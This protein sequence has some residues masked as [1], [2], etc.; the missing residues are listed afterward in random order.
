MSEQAPKRRGRP[1]LPPEVK[2]ERA[3]ERAR[4]RK[5]KQSSKH[6]ALAKAKRVLK[7]KEREAAKSTAHL[8]DVSQPI[9]VD[10]KLEA[11][12]VATQ[13]A[14]G[15]PSTRTDGIECIKCKRKLPT[16]GYNK[17]KKASPD[18][19][20]VYDSVC[21][22]CRLPDQQADL[23]AAAFERKVQRRVTTMIR[24]KKDG[25]VKK[26]D[27]VVEAEATKRVKQMKEVRKEAHKKEVVKASE[28]RAEKTIS[29][30]A[31][32]E[33]ARRE[34]ARRRLLYFTQRFEGQEVDGEGELVAIERAKGVGYKADWVHKD[35]CA[36]LERFLADARAGKQPRL[37][38]FMPPRHGKSTLASRMFPAWAY[39][40]DPTL[41]II[42][43]SYGASLPE[44][45]SRN[46]RGILRDPEYKAIF[47]KTR[48]DPDRENVQGWATSKNGMYIPV[49]VGSGIT[50]KGADILII[51]DPFKGAE[52]AEN[53]NQREKVV[54]WYFSEAYTRLSPNAGVLII[55][56]RW[57]DAD[58][59]GSLLEAQK[60]QETESREILDSE[61][62]EIEAAQLSKFDNIKAISLASAAHKE[63]LV[64]V[65]K[66]EV[67]SFAAIADQNEFRLPDG[68]I[69]HGRQP[70]AQLLRRA[71]EALHPSRYP[72]E[73]LNK[74]RKNFYA[75]GRQRF[76]HALYQQKPVPDEG[77]HFSREMVRMVTP[78]SDQVRN[79]WLK[80][81]AWDLAAGQDA[82]HDWTVG[83]HGQMD[84]EGRIH[85]MEIVR[86]RFD[87]AHGVACEVLDEYTRNRPHMIGVEKGPLEKYLQPS[88]KKELAE[89]NKALNYKDRLTPVFAEGKGYALAPIQDPVMRAQPLQSVMQQ[90]MFV[91]S[92][93]LQWIEEAIQELIR[94]PGGVHDDIVTA[95]SWLVRLML[96]FEVP[97]AP[98]LKQRQRS[99]KHKLNAYTARGTR[100]HMAA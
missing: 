81:T 77:V 35:I 3:A 16:S 28:T 53:P 56:T 47:P 72:I 76:W 31:A 57:H 88:I 1:P 98:K 71:G 95:L 43:A 61:M 94:F 92:K 65:E 83:A 48:L 84:Y 55:L 5:S 74:I 85:V 37:M 18:S 62:A 87:G 11:T 49:G 58:L 4:A 64:D 45:F 42:A 59:A 7:R 40:Q 82:Q 30:N 24:G 8:A 41:E 99:W 20:V 66:W 93:D 68:R 29:E 67:V 26:S 23:A 38:L 51:D 22:A 73:R 100:G 79:G 39:G 17:L 86:G 34:L 13:P 2:A 27:P 91:F 78:H 96:K 12:G 14:P 21:K 32:R 19:P 25:R 44:Q 75:R 63:R 50:G 90:G 60:E 10:A 33:L 97:N 6:S 46:V 9:R 36:R 89:R 70:K 54:D 52:D 69:V 80:L 15:I